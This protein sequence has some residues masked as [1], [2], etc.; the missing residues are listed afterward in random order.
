LTI[1]R[2]VSATYNQNSPVLLCLYPH[3]SSRL[4][5]I[6]SVMHAGLA[7]YVHIRSI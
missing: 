4:T 5:P 3:G 6:L 2:A 7:R 1:R